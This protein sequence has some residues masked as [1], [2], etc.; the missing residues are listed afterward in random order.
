MKKEKRSLSSPPSA[1]SMLTS[2]KSLLPCPSARGRV[3][4]RARRKSPRRVRVSPSAAAE[5]EVLPPPA[6]AAV[7]PILRP[8]PAVQKVPE[9]L[10]PIPLQKKILVLVPKISV[11]V[12]AKERR[13]P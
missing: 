1:N 10:G 3:K 2:W 11:N 4:R 12:N 5:R 13:N 8:V 6:A 9:V 7:T